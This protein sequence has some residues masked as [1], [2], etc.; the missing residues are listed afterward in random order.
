MVNLRCMGALVGLVV[1]GCATAAQASWYSSMKE[2]EGS[3]RGHWTAVRGGQNEGGACTLDIWTD[4]H[5]RWSETNLIFSGGIVR[6]GDIYFSSFGE[7]SI[8][9]PMFDQDFELNGYYSQYIGQGTHWRP[10]AGRIE[11]SAR[12]I[13][14]PLPYWIENYKEAQ[15]P[16]GRT[17]TGRFHL[18]NRGK[19]RV[20]TMRYA[21]YS[22]GNAIPDFQISFS[23]REIR[24]R[25][26]EN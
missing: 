17:I 19:K 23:V 11:F 26:A 1:I 13:H 6:D 16:T 24:S 8:N 7:F 25:K 3:Y 2:W 22:P 18:R 10:G 20:V 5:G 12:E 15:T 14:S 21:I 4:K 9:T